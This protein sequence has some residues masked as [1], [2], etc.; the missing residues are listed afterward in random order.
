MRYLLC[1][2]LIL[3]RLDELIGLTQQGVERFLWGLLYG[4]HLDGTVEG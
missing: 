2:E 4:C 1:D 3:A